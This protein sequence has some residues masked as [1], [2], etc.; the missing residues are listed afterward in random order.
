METKV[1]DEGGTTRSRLAPL[2]KAGVRGRLC[3]LT[4]GGL[5]RVGRRA[6]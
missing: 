5:I 4:T 2:Q 3:L 1:G 6:L